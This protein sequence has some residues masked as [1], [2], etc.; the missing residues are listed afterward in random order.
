MSDPRIESMMDRQKKDQRSPLMKAKAQVQDGGVVNFCPFGCED[1]ELDQHG[2]CKHL[3]G[4]TNDRKTY[5]PMVWDSGRQARIVRV[6][7]TVDKDGKP[8]PVLEPCQK[9]DKFVQISISSRVYR[10]TEATPE[11]L[12]VK[13]SKA[14]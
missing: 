4:F 12:D 6:K 2:Y 13:P 9:G 11:L 5:E 10:N 1:S 7:Q 8:V 14:K 3:V